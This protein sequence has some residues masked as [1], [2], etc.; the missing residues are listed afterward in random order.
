[1]VFYSN[2]DGRAFTEYR[3]FGQIESKIK[4]VNGISNNY[5]YKLYLQ[6]N[7]EKIMN[8]ERQFVNKSVAPICD[9]QDCMKLTRQKFA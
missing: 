4:N 1:M 7:A 3:S 6:R 2:E 9:C 8:K 5:D